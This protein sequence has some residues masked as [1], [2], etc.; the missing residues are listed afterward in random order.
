MKK[1]FLVLL[2][3]SF[4]S[5]II[6]H[7]V[8]LMYSLR[9]EN[10]YNDTEDKGF[11]LNYASFSWGDN[12]FSDYAFTFSLS[13]FSSAYTSVTVNKAWLKIPIIKGLECRIGKQYHDFG[14]L[15]KSGSC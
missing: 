7:E 3:I 14:N 10:Q 4:T 12:D 8:S 5:S 13:E 6:A 15:E 1:A 2:L 11:K 9:D